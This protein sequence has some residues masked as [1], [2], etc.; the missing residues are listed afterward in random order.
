MFVPVR[1]KGT[2][3]NK[4]RVT[5]LTSEADPS[6]PGTVPSSRQGTIDDARAN[7]AIGN[8]VAVL[9][10]LMPWRVAMAVGAMVGVSLSEGIGLL[11]VVALLNL[12]GLDVQQGTVGW[13]AQLV[14]LTF[15]FVGMQPTL[16]PVL[17]IYVFIVSLHALFARWQNIA[18]ATIEN[19]FVAHL[20]EEL[21]LSILKTTWL[22]FSRRRASDF[23]HALT[24]ELDRV[25]AATHSLLSLVASAIVIMIYL[26]IALQL[27]GVMTGLV[28][29][30][31]SGLF[32]A[33]RSRIQAAG[34]SGE[35]LSS[36]T[37]ELYSTVS[38]HLTGMKAAKSYAAER[39]HGDIFSRL[40]RR[41]TDVYVDA[42]RSQVDSKL[43]FEIGS[44]MM[45]SCILY[46]SL[47]IL[48]VPAAAVLMLLLLFVR[49]MPKIS[50]IQQHSQGFVQ[51]LPAFT[52][53]ARLQAQ[54]DEAA[55][56]QSAWSEGIELR[57]A[58]RLEQVSFGYEGGEDRLIFRDLDLTI[59]AGQTTAI[60]GPSGAGKS[61]IADLVIGLVAPER[62][63]VLVDGVPLTPQHMW[64]WRRQIGYVSQET[65][66]FH[67]TVRTN[68]LWARPD[69]DDEELW[70]ALRMSAAEEFVRALPNG[71]ETVVGDRGIRLS[72]GERQRVALARALVRRPSILILDEATSS[73]DSENER[74]IQSAIDLLHGRITI[75]VIAHRL[76]TIRSVDGIHVVEH[77]RL[78]ESGNWG[79]LYA[80][81]DSRLR[82]L[83]Q[84]QDVGML[85]APTDALR[86]SGPGATRSRSGLRGAS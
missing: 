33:L 53:V 60:V 18:V 49:I 64:S 3:Q 17:A 75:L 45:L 51:G 25:Y 82:A 40:S 5:D 35:R 54:C 32:L 84:A 41:L 39:V 61:T 28:F 70:D 7:A 77:G 76:S 42:V 62:G 83:C 50:S 69:A 63:R 78:T 73:L 12:V 52:T 85:S 57:E 36:A 27:S 74:R 11:L 24:T 38:E 16:V 8:Y 37:N 46:V 20:R 44:V 43:W 26:I 4:R 6:L 31:G 72:G 86:V 19:E 2:S 66:L 1:V 21:Y 47:E 59:R 80:R 68:L 58:I 79:D 13:F 71:L 65:F 56:P 23:S 10:R 55:E 14:W 9:L 15:T 22:F 29:V 48:A 30:C 81:S 34:R 67:D